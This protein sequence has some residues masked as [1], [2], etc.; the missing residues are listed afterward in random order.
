MNLLG[1]L[2]QVSDAEN[3][4]RLTRKKQHLLKLP[5]F[6]Y[7]KH[8]AASHVYISML[9]SLVNKEQRHIM[10]PGLNFTC[11]FVVKNFFT[12]RNNAAK[13]NLE[14]ICS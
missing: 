1:T 12:Q 7:A 6:S 13:D 9:L 5:V 4:T 8:P 10:F 11:N 3:K 2:L 14:H